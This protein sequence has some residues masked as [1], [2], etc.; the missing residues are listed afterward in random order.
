MRRIPALRIPQADE[1]AFAL[2]RVQ[3]M[4]PMLTWRYRWLNSHSVICVYVVMWTRAEVC[5]AQRTHGDRLGRTRP[6]AISR[7]GGT[8]LFSNISN[9]SGGG[10]LC[11][12]P[13]QLFL[14]LCSFPESKCSS[15]SGHSIET[16][17][18]ALS[19]SLLPHSNLHSTAFTAS[20]SSRIGHLRLSGIDPDLQAPYL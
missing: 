15:I 2:T 14:R 8:D 12:E 19:A 16:E 9:D 7:T 18:L 10:L 3:P 11:G 17:P 20:D 13:S 5:R 1:T 4:Q 6:T